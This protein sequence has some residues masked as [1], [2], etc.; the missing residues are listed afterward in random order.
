M[1]QLRD[2]TLLKILTFLDL[3]DLLKTAMVCRRFRY[4][5]RTRSV[6]DN[7]IVPK[8]KT[9]LQI[10]KTQQQQ[11]VLP[12]LAHDP[13][14]YPLWKHVDATTFVQQAYQT[15]YALQKDTASQGKSKKASPEQWAREQTGKTLA[16]FLEGKTPHS[17][18]IR[19]I[20]THLCA[21]HLE[22]PSA[23]LVSLEEL[24]LT[25]F[26]TLSDTHLHV[27]LLLTLGGKRGSTAM[28]PEPFAS[29][30]EARHQLAKANA[31]P[32][33]HNNL[34]VLRLEFCPQLT[35][36][37]VVSIAKTCHKHLNQLSLKGNSQITSIEA[38]QELFVTRLRL[39]KL[40]HEDQTT[41]SIRQ[42]SSTPLTMMLPRGSHFDSSTKTSAFQIPSKTAPLSHCTSSF[43]LPPPLPTLATSKTAPPP[44]PPPSLQTSATFPNALSGLFHASPPPPIIAK[45]NG[46]NHGSKEL[47]MRSRP[48]PPLPPPNTRS[49]LST[50][51]TAASTTLGS[52]F[53]LPP[54]PPLGP[55]L[56][57]KI[58]SFSP[59]SCMQSNIQSLH[60]TQTRPKNETK[61]EPLHPSSRFSP[62][63]P[64]HNPLTS[65][66]DPPG[67]SPPRP[68]LNLV[69]P[70]DTPK[71]PPSLTPPRDS[72]KTFMVPIDHDKGTNFS[73][74]A[75]PSQ[76]PNPAMLQRYHR[77]RRS[78]SSTFKLA[79]AAA[80]VDSWNGDNTS[81]HDTAA[82]NAATAS[83]HRIGTLEHLDV[84][85]TSISPRHA[86]D[87]LWGIASHRH[88]DTAMSTSVRD[89]NEGE[90]WC[91]VCFK[92]LH[93]N[94][95]R[96]ERKSLSQ[97]GN[98][99]ADMPT[100]ITGCDFLA[101]MDDGWTQHEVERL[102]TVLAMD[103]VKDL[104]LGS[105]ALQ[106]A[107]KGHQVQNWQK[108]L[109]I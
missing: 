10:V 45:T 71:L 73:S 38:L 66:F 59:E 70:S 102:Q 15:F 98:V 81:T 47:L 23:L 22:M 76:S 12:V 85:G 57:P 72:H 65:L 26:D 99:L 107:T 20:G 88:T 8:L 101:T 32:R 91:W 63:S 67:S 94:D 75:L 5:I 50:E 96:A 36:A 31:N 97:D 46:T 14:L 42:N 9:K 80:T 84:R 82:V 17:L 3:A 103:E 43:A 56:A 55:S 28:H 83:G 41:A 78:L 11:Q 29:N 108:L 52:L 89:V 21:N 51:T 68:T 79:G 39:D 4:H 64:T 49:S 27:L 6:Q 24:T 77:H 18:V 104:S 105:D 60:D 1:D 109:L 58:G 54:K 34:R 48:S 16:K 100:T 19:N 2:D 74:A 95:S 40:Q 35:D 61:S 93:L 62:H 86:V 106:I 92:S 53:A 37:S 25:H 44:P 30:S 69:M 87:C 7:E 90:L 33:S 13:G